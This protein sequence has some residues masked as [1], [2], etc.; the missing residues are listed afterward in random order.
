MAKK[1]ND[2]QLQCLICTEEMHLDSNVSACPCGH[3]F[4][5]ICLDEWFKNSVRRTCPQ[6]R[7]L[8]GSNKLIIKRLYF[9]ICIDDGD[10]K[11]SPSVGDL[12]RE[13][14]DCKRKLLEAS[15]ERDKERS[16][17]TKILEEFSELQKCNRNLK[18][19]AT[20]YR[21][22]RNRYNDL[23]VKYDNLEKKC[24]VEKTLRTAMTGTYD[25]FEKYLSKN[26][27]ESGAMLMPEHAARKIDEL[28][29]VCLALHKELHNATQEIHKAKGLV[30]K[31]FSVLHKRKEME[32][33]NTKIDTK[34]LPVNDLKQVEAE[35]QLKRFEVKRETLNLFALNT[36][37]LNSSL[38]TRIIN[39]SPLP[40]E[41]EEKKRK[42]LG[43]DVI[44]IIDADATT[45][46]DSLNEPVVLP[47]YPR[48]PV[49]PVGFSYNGRGG[50]TRQLVAPAVLKKNNLNKKI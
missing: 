11:A 3:I 21:Q 49:L 46:N 28:N 30:Y 29:C 36:S 5:G 19:E 12:K 33:V 26:A 35:K 22:L 34:P 16:E 37:R 38:V 13:L 31:R 24:S 44:E 7:F 14:D 15:V 40:K 4:H 2:V 8:I 18:A 48:L 27:R 1:F 9:P 43:N 20:M 39:E 17:K 42:L 41:I 10:L 23:K 6:C 32:S 25:E 45:A 50:R 47:V